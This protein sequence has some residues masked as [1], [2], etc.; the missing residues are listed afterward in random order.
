MTVSDN[1]TS[2]GAAGRSVDNVS[3]PDATTPVR[4]DY[5]G[6]P[7]G[8]YDTVLREGN[9][10]RRLWHT[11]KFDR[12]LDYL[13]ERPGQSILDIGCFAG[14]FLSMVPEHRF[15]Q[16]VGVD[17]LPG[18]VDFAN[19]NYGTSFRK[20][21]HVA[22]I[23]ALDDL[24]ETFD[25]ITL[26]E[27]IEH[28][29]ADEIR[30]LFEVAVSKLK[31]GG[32]FVVTT[33]NYASA[34]PAIEII[35][36]RVSEVSY[37]EQHITRFNYFNLERKLLDIYPDLGLYFN[38]PVFK[39]TTHFVTPFLAAFSFEIARGLSRVVPHRSWHHPFGNLILSVFTR[40]PVPQRSA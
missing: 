23:G 19:A 20:F 24:K 22:K 3:V 18:Q 10:I 7:N 8:Y 28:L 29:N 6:I 32:K 4:F 16:Q 12:V 37:E 40:S 30:T 14:T 21:R 36:N 2:V 34:W 15:S 27:V 31:P 9:P 38:S 1:Q 35:L 25:C 13:P 33:P 17:I 26:I 39:T 11:S 5:D